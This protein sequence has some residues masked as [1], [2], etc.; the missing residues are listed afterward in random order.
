ME[1]ILTLCLPTYNRG[2]CVKEQ[3]SRLRQCPPEIFDKVEVLV[4]DNCSTDDTRSVIE[5]FKNFNLPVKYIRN[6]KN[7]GADGNFIQC[8]KTANTKYVWLLGDDDF[9]IVDS[10]CRIVDILD[11]PKE[12]GLI[13]ISQ[14]LDIHHEA[15]VEYNNSDSFVSCVSYWLTFISSNII[16][17]KYAHS[18]AYENYIGKWLPYVP[19]YLTSAYK[20][21][22]NLLINFQTF[23]GCAAAQSNGGYNFIKVFVESFLDILGEFIEGGFMSKECYNYIKHDLYKNYVIN[24]LTQLFVFNKLPNFDRTGAGEILLKYYGKDLYFYGIT[25]FAMCRAYGALL[26]H[27][28]K[29][30]F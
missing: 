29:N 5:E 2:W 27:K 25:S 23:E 19:Y 9:I 24:Y 7:L 11:V 26:F 12:Y 20:F 16:N 17:T 4:S 6:E 13:H 21:N 28:L 30:L 10:L 22:S 18:I 3:L 8:I 1:K 14:N 15:K